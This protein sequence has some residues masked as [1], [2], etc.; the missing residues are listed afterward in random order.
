MDGRMREGHRRRR[1]HSLER[2]AVALTALTKWPMW[3]HYGR[4]K[5]RRARAWQHNTLWTDRQRQRGEQKKH[6]GPP[7]SIPNG[8]PTVEPARPIRLTIPPFYC[9]ACQLSVRCVASVTSLPLPPSHRRSSSARFILSEV[10]FSCSC[11][12]LASENQ[13]NSAPAC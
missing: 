4:R 12:F 8:Q 13:F 6:Q 3:S 2:G 9:V 11:P 7:S 5:A 1:P 10:E